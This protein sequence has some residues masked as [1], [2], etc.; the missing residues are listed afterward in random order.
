MKTPLIRR[1][2]RNSG[3]ESGVT[4]V[5][6]AVAMVAIVA[7]AALSIDVITLYLAKQEAQRSADAAAIAAAKIL[8]VS[9]L[10]GDPNNGS[11]RWGAICGP[12]DGTNGLATRV[13]KA[14]ANQNLVGGA[15]TSTPIVTYSSA[16]TSSSDCTALSTTAFGVNPMVTVQLNRP[17]LP[18]F[19]SRI[20][21]NRGNSISA[22]A[23]AELFNPSNSANSGN[24]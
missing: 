18:T 9:S 13:A 11:L 16:G 14:V 5:L 20:W 10:T 24:S 21:G 22:T 3:R 1:Q 6:V 12:D 17:N 2:F 4:M 19:F 7:M 23:T 8:S 15:T